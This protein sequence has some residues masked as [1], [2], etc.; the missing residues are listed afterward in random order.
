M[1]KDNLI[2][3]VIGV[4]DVKNGSRKLEDAIEPAD[5][6][7]SAIH[8][9][10]IDAGLSLEASRELQTGIDSVDVVA[11]WTW[12]YPDLPALLS[13][14]L[15]IQ[16]QHKFYS[17]HAGNAPGKLFDDAARR[18]SQGKNKIAILTGG[19]ALASLDAFSRAGKP[20]PLSWTK[21]ARSVTEVFRPKGSGREENVGTIHSVGLPLHVYP[22]YEN[23]FRAYRKQSMQ[24][25][26][27]ES[28]RLYADFSVVAEKNPLSWNYGKPAETE[29]SLS[30]VTRRNRMICYPY[31]LLM[32][33][34][35]TVNLAAACILT[36]TDTARRLGV[37]ED[38]WI[39]PLGGAG[40]E[41]S[42]YFWERPNFHSCPSISRSLDAALQSS[43]L[44]K[45]DVDLFDF[46]SCF[47][48]VPKLAAH[49]L[50]LPLVNNPK[51]ITLLGG[52]TSFGG[53]GNNYS[54]HAITEMVR[55]LRKDTGAPRHG[56]I[57]ANGGVL[58]Y[59]HV[60]C[61]SSSQRKDG[62]PYP[63]EK[64]LPE[65][66]TDVEVPVVDSQ[67]EGEATIE[68]YTVEFSRDGSPLCAYIVGLLRSNGHRF[69]ANHADDSTL[70]ELS[71]LDREPIGRVGYA[72]KDPEE[73][74]R[75]LFSL[76]RPTKL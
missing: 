24:D 23:G 52:L 34:F 61:L 8:K 30:T 28:A 58:S 3:V 67:A 60:I 1:A 48:I 42:N 46:Y 11:T 47:P 27:K 7:L 62:A 37:P 16:P 45:E 59:Q 10:I 22:L 69:I 40:T 13:D 63:V 50:G 15:G 5:L 32:N 19:E 72:T 33:A 57:L 26:V 39:Y 2:P 44:R 76:S 74:G 21:P 31:P 55:Q 36:T 6:M 17:H 75:N 20:P 56:L 38:Q 71:N 73:E 43:G 70:V 12:P 25:N 9:A 49:H 54:M 29:Q 53:A 18:L 68:T 51:P 41:D 14:K 4:G 66:V 64:P 35:N 65:V